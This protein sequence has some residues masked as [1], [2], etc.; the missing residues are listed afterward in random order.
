MILPTIII[1]IIFYFMILPT[2]AIW[3]LASGELVSCPCFVSI[4]A[5]SYVVQPEPSLLE[6]GEGKEV[7]SVT[8][9]RKHTQKQNCDAHE[10]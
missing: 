5:K 2:I 7:G 10:G 3:V 8:E 4:K 6:N 1:I 9:E